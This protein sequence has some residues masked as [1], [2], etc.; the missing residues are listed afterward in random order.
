MHFKICISYSEKIGLNLPSFLF[1]DGKVC[2][3]HQGEAEDTEEVRC[4]IPYQSGGDSKLLMIVEGNG[5]A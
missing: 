5:L 1:V 3:C 2:T 4:D